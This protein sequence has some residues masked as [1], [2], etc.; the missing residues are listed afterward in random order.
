MSTAI[1]RFVESARVG[2][3][4]NAVC[5]VASGWIILG[6]RQVV[7]GY[8]LL[9]PDPVVPNLNA[10]DQSAREVFLRDMTNLGDVLL[11]ITGA[12]RINYEIL[13]NLEPALHAHV[14]PRY[15]HEP[16]ELRSKPI[17]F[18][19]WDSAPTFELAT[20]QAIMDDIRN[21]MVSRR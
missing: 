10:L 17:W 21:R 15:D 16:E 7:P 13:G 14:L 3:L 5:R 8:C 20:H 9:L 12:A 2:S 19:E 1:H 11:G 4:P 6:E 18:Y